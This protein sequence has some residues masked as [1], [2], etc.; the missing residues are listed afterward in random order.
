MISRAKID[1]SSQEEIITTEVEHPDGIA[2][3][4]IAR[5]LYWTDTGTDRIE[6]ARLNGKARKVHYL[7]IF[8][9]IC[10]KVI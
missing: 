9:I 4:W 2:V 8:L 5:N 6:V 7:L 10:I 1:G 3:D